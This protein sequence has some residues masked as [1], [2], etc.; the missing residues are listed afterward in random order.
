MTALKTRVSTK[1][2]V[3]LPNAIRR[4]RRWEAGTELLVEDTEAG[5]LLRAAPYFPPTTIDEVSRLSA[6]YTG[7]VVTLEEMD[8]AV[9]A[10]E[11]ATTCARLIPISWSESW[12]R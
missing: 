9:W 5:V 11:A 6:N 1:G 3:I 10:E 4:R 8:E 7:P 2:Q 12:R